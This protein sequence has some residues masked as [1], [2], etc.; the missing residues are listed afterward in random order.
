[1]RMVLILIVAGVMMLAARDGAQAQRPPAPPAT[2]PTSLQFSNATASS[3][4]AFL[5]LGDNSAG[6]IPDVRLVDVS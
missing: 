1:M 3:V 5:T 6:R 4:T 2:Q